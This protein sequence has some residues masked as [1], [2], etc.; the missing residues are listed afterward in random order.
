M[1]FARR[2]S[3]SPAV[4]FAYPG[5]FVASGSST[6]GDIFVWRVSDGQLE[7]K[8]SA[9]KSGVGCFAWGRGGTSGQQ[10]ASADGS[11]VL[12]LWA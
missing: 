5:T 2:D 3:N 6:S 7:K 4:F 1:F 8:L 11:G 9:H 12:V 10:V